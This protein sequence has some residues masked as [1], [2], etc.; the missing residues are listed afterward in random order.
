MFWNFWK[1]ENLAR[2]QK[3]FFQKFPISISTC[4][5]GLTDGPCSVFYVFGVFLSMLG[6]FLFENIENFRPPKI[7]KITN[8]IQIVFDIRYQLAE[9]FHLLYSLWG[10]RDKSGLT[11]SRKLFILTWFFLILFNFSH[12]FNFF[13]P[14]FSETGGS[15]YSWRLYEIWDPQVI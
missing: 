14:I 2:V 9:F 13:P 11:N 15:C 4:R 5:A 3:I 6:R 12:F 8:E 10:F 1:F 7:F